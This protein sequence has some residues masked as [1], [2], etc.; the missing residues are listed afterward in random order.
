MF[1]QSD[2]NLTTNADLLLN[3]TMTLGNVTEQIT[4]SAEASR[5]STESATLQQLVD[6]KRITDLPLNGRDVYQLARLVPGV[7]QDGTHIGGG[8]SGSQNSTMVNS[9]VDGALNVNM[10]FT[11]VLPSPSPDAV[12]EFTIQ[13]SVPPAKYGFAAGVIEVSTRS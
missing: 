11:D 4:V 3:I 7:G 2:V 8:R 13:T 9:R 6:S 1:V 5:V 12:Q 10:A